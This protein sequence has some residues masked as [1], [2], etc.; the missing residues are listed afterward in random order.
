M[1]MAMS[2]M[3]MDLLTPVLSQCTSPTDCFG[4]GNAP[5]GFEKLILIG[6]WVLWIAT[7]VCVIG[8]VV[9]GAQMAIAHQH[10]ELQQHGKR[11]GA[12]MLGI[13]VIGT[14]SGITAAL[15]G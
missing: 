8:L 6:Q 14:A 10:G 13:I 1:T 11:L 2:H 12:V 15:I 9:V 3:V 5:P 7:A 4:R